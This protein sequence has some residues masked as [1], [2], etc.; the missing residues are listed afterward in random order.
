M[1]GPIDEA[2]FDR[3]ISLFGLDGQVA[4][5]RCSVAIV[6]LGG[7]GSHVSQQL[8]YLGVRK[9]TLIDMDIVTRS[10]LNRVIGATPEDAEAGRS[11]VEVGE[12]EVLRILPR[13]VVSAVPASFVSE[14]AFAAVRNVGLLFGCLDNDPI[15]FALN[16]F[17]Q[18]YQ[19]PY[20]DLA[21][22]THQES[23]GEVGFGGRILYSVGGE[24]CLVCCD[25]LDSRAL[26]WAFSTD[27]Q[28]AETD[29]IY[30][31]PRGDLGGTGPA[32]VSLN[33]TLASLAVTEF[34]VE[35]VDLRAA[36]RHIEYRGM[37]GLFGVRVDRSAPAPDCYYCKELYGK[38]DAADLLRYVREGWGARISDRG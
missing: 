26:D 28:R 9:L 36:E 23:D 5:E 8:A 29:A 15:R 21:S 17:A 3:Q 30:G 25:L 20:M 14:Q 27:R 11:K 19:I 22:D 16:E 1:T 31:V 33:G 18:A 10:S 13:A 35:Q 37:G 2:R 7:L 4:L 6:G 32:V 34:M 24:R 12:R 38:G